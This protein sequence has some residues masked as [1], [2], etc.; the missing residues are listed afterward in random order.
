[1]TRTTTRRDFHINS[2]LLGRNYYLPLSLLSSCANLRSN[3]SGF[4]DARRQSQV[5][6]SIKNFYYAD[7]KIE[8]LSSRCHGKY[9]CQFHNFFSL[10]FLQVPHPQFSSSCIISTLDSCS[11]LCAWPD[12]SSFMF[13][14][15]AS[16]NLQL[17]HRTLC[18]KGGT[19]SSLYGR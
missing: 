13:E 10:V 16:H 12:I 19:A 11:P 4:N 5:A 1:M 2:V 9:D 14:L 3:V 7:P 8:S 15:A 6:G 18:F 17:I